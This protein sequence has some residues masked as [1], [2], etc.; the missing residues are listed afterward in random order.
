MCIVFPELRTE[1]AALNADRGVYAGVEI[2]RPPKELGCDLIF[3]QTRPRVIDAMLRQIAKQFA[4]RLRP[5]EYLT[6]N[7]SFDL[8]K[9]LLT[10]NSSDPGNQH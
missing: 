4:K 1:A 8:L 7:D 6:G 2:R 3:L 10:V 9:F 5:V